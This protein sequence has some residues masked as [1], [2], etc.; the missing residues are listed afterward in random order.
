MKPG[1][2]H[3]DEPPCATLPAEASGP[4]SRIRAGIQSRLGRRLLVGILATSSLITLVLTADQLYREYR[5]DVRAIEQ[6]L[7][8]IELTQ[9]GAITNQLWEL[10]DEILG[11]TLNGLARLPEIEFL[12]VSSADGLVQTAGSREANHTRERRFPLRYDT[13]RK[14]VLIGS[15]HVVASLAPAR[16]RLFERLGATLMRNAA[17]TFIVSGVILALVHLLVIR[18]LGALGAFCRAWRVDDDTRPPLPSAD[19]ARPDEIDDMN[20][21]VREMLEGI[22]RSYSELRAS[23]QRYRQLIETAEEGVWLLDEHNN[24]RFVNPRLARMLGHTREE[25]AGRPLLDFID[26]DERAVALVYLQRSRSG[27]VEQLELALRC[28]DDTRRWVLMAASPIVSDDGERRGTLA[29][30]TDIDQRKRAEARAN[31][32]AY[33]DPLTQLPNRAFLHNRLGEALARSLR[34][35]EFGALLFLD[36]DN[37]KTVNDSRG[38]RIGD[39]VLTTV[40]VRLRETLRDADFVSRFG[41]DEF[42]ILLTELHRERDSAAAIASGI[43]QKLALPWQRQLKGASKGIDQKTITTTV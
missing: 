34:S 28:A 18:R 13:G 11:Q 43:G 1:T 30:V 42:V 29:M 23:E 5:E 33:F 21:A 4:G 16:E 17:K 15:L 24:T 40:A 25:L 2:G 3:F 36:L 26:E 6:R 22:E 27:Q 8:E 41:G 32:L 39:S 31:E 10:N 20:S 9:T 12:Q 7:Q 37:F 19:R 38:H 35:G 14:T